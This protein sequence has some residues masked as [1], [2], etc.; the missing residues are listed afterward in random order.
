MISNKELISLVRD[1]VLETAKKLKADPKYPSTTISM[2]L[3]L[4]ENKKIDDSTILE[5]N[6]ILGIK[7][8][9]GEFASFSTIQQGLVIAYNND[10]STTLPAEYSKDQ[11]R[12]CTA[13]NLYN[14]DKSYVYSMNNTVD[15]SAEQKKP[16]IDQYTIKSD[17]GAVIGKATT[18]D[19]A[20]QVAETSGTKTT[21]VNSV[22]EVVKRVTNTNMSTPINSPD[23]TS[24]SLQAGAKIEVTD[25]N[26]YKSSK[27]TAPE[28]LLSGTFY[29]YDGIDYFGKVAICL[30]PNPSTI[31]DIF[32]FIN[33][34][35]L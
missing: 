25:V 6:N 34:S 31:S 23:V 21:I 10:T 3:W 28:R 24:L 9:N 13:N 27:S 30:N 2:M 7:D 16:S 17:I 5:C 33:K 32:G 18:L 1:E 15:L 12:I 14:I 26:L 29:L 11:H 35:S 19:E 8:D 22:G 20:E 4:Y